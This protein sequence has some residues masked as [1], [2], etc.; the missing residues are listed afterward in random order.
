MRKFSIFAVNK[1]G[2]F[3]LFRKVVALFFVANIA[4]VI[5]IGYQ[6][7]A[8]CCTLRSTIE[9]VSSGGDSLFYVKYFN[10]HLQMTGSM[11]KASS[12]KHSSAQ[13]RPTHETGNLIHLFFKDFSHLFNR[14][15]YVS[16]IW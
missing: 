16:G 5:H 8:N 14:N 7:P 3:L 4:Y 2:S 11:K 6:F 15:C 1:T 12:V 10:F 9:P 13:A